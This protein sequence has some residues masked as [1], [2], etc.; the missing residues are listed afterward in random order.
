[1]TSVA[2]RADCGHR[3]CMGEEPDRL[4]TA[5]TVVTLVRTALSVALAVVAVANGSTAWLAAALVAYWVGDIAD[6]ALARWLHAE[7]RTGA[8][9]D[10]VSDRCCV[11]LVY[12]PYATWNPEFAP[13]VGVYVFE[14]MVIDL[15]L[16]LGFLRWPI[17]SPNYFALVDRTLYRLNWT[18]LAKGTNSAG[19]AVA[20][21]LL[22]A[23]VLALV[24][25][26]VLL[27]VKVGSLVR[28][29]RLPAWRTADASGCVLA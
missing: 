4:V 1:M 16:S 27:A 5:P 18:P 23:P 15:F 20:A 22:D 13:A 3:G 6:G 10:I 9:L 14:F 12:L 19:I 8:V 11:A 17:R 28:L 7:T 26:V 24:V 29:T 21:V 2:V 25:A